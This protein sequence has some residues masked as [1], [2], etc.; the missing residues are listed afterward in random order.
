[1]QGTPGGVRNTGSHGREGRPGWGPLCSG[2]GPVP[3][4]QPCSWQNPAARLAFLQVVGKSACLLSKFPE[5][6]LTDCDLEGVIQPLM[7][8]VSPT[9]WW[10]RQWSKI[11]L[12]CEVAAH[13]LQ[14]FSLQHNGRTAKCT[15]KSPAPRI[16]T[17]RTPCHQHKGQ[18]TLTSA[19]KLCWNFPLE[20]HQHPDFSQH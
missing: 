18:E 7:G 20:C 17:K 2:H 3:C 5:L 1:M 19:P 14:T 4:R 15:C 16:F 9:G 8:T 13:T 6:Q 11:P 12:K 10:P